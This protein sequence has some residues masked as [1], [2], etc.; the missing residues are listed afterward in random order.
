VAIPAG[1]VRPCTGN[2]Q[3]A[4]RRGLLWPGGPPDKWDEAFRQGLQAHGYVDGQNIL[5]EYRWAE[6]R[7]DRLSELAEE[8]IRLKV[9]LIVTISAPAIIAVKQGTASIPIVFAATSDPVRSGF[10]ASL[11]RPGGN[12]R[13]G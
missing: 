11:A 8:L 1:A 10:V 9:D 7:Q 13:A 3:D 6:G 12:R 5:L 4:P 2:T